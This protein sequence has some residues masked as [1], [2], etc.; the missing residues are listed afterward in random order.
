MKKHFKNIYTSSLFPIFVILS[1]FLILHLPGI[2][3]PPLDQHAWR[4]ADTSAVARNFSTE[5]SNI[6]Y[7]RIDIRSSFSGVTGMEFPLYN[8]SLFIFNII[9]GFEYWHGRIITLLASLV[10]LFFFYKLMLA[11]YNL[12]RAV[13]ASS[14]L[15]ITPLWFYFSR[16]IQPDIAMVSLSIISLYFAQLYKDKKQ[17][18]FIVI[19]LLSLSL[20]CLIKIPAIFVGL[21]IISIIGIKTCLK[22]FRDYRFYILMLVGLIMPVALWYVHSNYLSNSFGLGQYY[23]GDLNISESAKLVASK[24]FWQVL[25]LYILPLSPLTYLSITCIFFGVIWSIFKKDYFPIV[26]AGVIL[27]FL[28][29]FSVK[30]FYHNYY[31]LPILPSMAIFFSSGTAWLSAI[32]KREWRLGPLILIILTFLSLSMYSFKTVKPWYQL[33]NTEFLQLE[34]IMKNVNPDNKLIVVNGNQNPIMMYFSGN[35]GWSLMNEDFN[36]NSINS[37]SAD[38][39]VQH[40]TDGLKKP[41]LSKPVVYSDNN[42]IIFKLR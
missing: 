13:I 16:N 32:I 12:K 41:A 5:S 33:A 21:V 28:S 14:F 7:P 15:A 36:E 10:G 31:S 29:V 2:T 39:A 38:F 27:L 4:Q 17:F 9:F 34:K 37:L 6:L 35:K 30:S 18:K 11:R 42:Y 25:N 40:T 26:W 19:S 24:Q 3:N 22:L 23:Y 8:F 20:A 1:V